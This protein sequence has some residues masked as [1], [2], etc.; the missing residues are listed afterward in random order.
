MSERRGPKGRRGGDHPSSRRGDRGPLPQR[1]RRG[2]GGSPEGAA[3][4][5]R[6]ESSGRSGPPASNGPTSRKPHGIKPHDRKPYGKPRHDRKPTAAAQGRSRRDDDRDSARPA[7]DDRGERLQKILASAGVGSRRSC[8]ELILRGRVSVDGKVVRELGTRVNPRKSNIEVDGQSI[9]PE[10][11]VYFAVHK[12][13]GYVSTNNDPSGKPRVLDLLPGVHERIYTVGRLDENSVGLILLMNDGELA[14][15]LAH[16]KFGVEKVYRV[17]VAGTPTAEVL[18]KLTEG[19]WLAEGKV[20]ARRVRIVGKR[21]D[22]TILEMVLAEGKNR[23]VRRML[24]QFGHKVMALTRISVGPI[25]LGG[26]K[27]G[28]CRP[29]TRREVDLLRK[30]AAGEEIKPFDRDRPRE[31]RRES[32]QHVDNRSGRAS[33]ADV[34]QTERPHANADKRPRRPV[35]NAEKRYERPQANA[36]KRYERP[37]A[38]AEKRYERPQVNAEKRYE[39]PQ[40]NAEKRP[41]RPQANAEKRY[42][43]P[44]ANAGSSNQNDRPADD[45]RRDQNRRVGERPAGGPGDLKRAE[46]SASKENK[47]VDRP[48]S[49]AGSALRDESSLTDESTSQ[50]DVHQPIKPDTRS[51]LSHSGRRSII[52][53]PRSAQPSDQSDEPAAESTPRERRKPAAFLGIP[54]TKRRPIDDQEDLGVIVNPIGSDDDRPARG[55]QGKKR[56]PWIEPPKPRVIGLEDGVPDGGRKRPAGPRKP[57]PRKRPAGG[58]GKIKFTPRGRSNHQASDRSPDAEGPKG[59]S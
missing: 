46:R 50:T 41:E 1:E 23:E 3:R 40:A 21:G 37:Q 59:D 51:G 30:V 52:G 39:R 47:R 33:S 43:R 53:R 38:N 6:D 55:S 56:G 14:N 5:N 42:E 44:Q 11:H 9:E 17:V 34:N 7:E 29:L 13:R 10:R 27:A 19:V 31:Y 25:A 26:L 45:S 15:K 2:P 48:R 4:D 24:A 54:Q 36:E 8:E 18:K 57:A 28:M 12:P 20:R 32:D 49:N 58:G 35:T 16:P 22:A